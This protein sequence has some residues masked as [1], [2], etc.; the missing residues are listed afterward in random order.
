MLGIGGESFG[1]PG[2]R[3]AN[4]REDVALALERFVFPFSQLGA[5]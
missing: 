1:E 3:L 2:A 5:V 4:V